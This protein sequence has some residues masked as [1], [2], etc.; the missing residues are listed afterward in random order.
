MR[1]TFDKDADAV[2]IYFKDISQGEI[3]NTVSVNDY[4]KMDIN[5]DKKILGMEILNINQ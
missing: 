4:I 1:I 3:K 5:N 2:Y